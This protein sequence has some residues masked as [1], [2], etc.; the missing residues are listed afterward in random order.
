[1]NVKVKFLKFIDFTIGSIVSSLLH[2]TQK[3]PEQRSL[4][5]IDGPILVIRPGGIG[6][7]IMLLPL[8]KTLLELYP[9]R[10][11][12]VLCERRNEAIFKIA[13][14]HIKTV[15]YDKKSLSLITYLRRRKYAVVLDTEQYHNFSAVFAKI[16]KA[17]L[18]IGFN[19][20]PGRLSAYTR[21]VGYNTQGPEDKEFFRLL[22]SAVN[23]RDE[24]SADTLPFESKQRAGIMKNAALP[25]LPESIDQIKSEILLVHAGGSIPQKRCPAKIMAEMCK[26]ANREFGLEVIVIGSNA[27]NKYAQEIVQHSNN[28]A[29]N[30]CGQLSLAE[31]AAL[32]KKALIV[33]GPD[34]AV[35]HLAIAVGTHV[36]MIFGPGNPVKWG[37]DENQ[38]IVVQG[39]VM[40]AP[41]SV[42]GYTRR[43]SN[44]ECT[45]NIT[46]EHLIGSLRSI[47]NKMEN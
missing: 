18:R 2:S 35:A 27:D 42:F 36:V 22:Y 23:V 30:Y 44:P 28:I 46:S 5:E 21:L 11:I 34:S 25:D 38:G 24:S 29:K 15:C 6:D 31:S 33:V 4:S 10:D 9:Q 47:L 3:A 40:C 39:D 41:C 8:L 43:C 45:K 32:C 37:P 19:T 16:T 12:E 20:N 13:L 7:A 26:F 17:P 1:M 14:P